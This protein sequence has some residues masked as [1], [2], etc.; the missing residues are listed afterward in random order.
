M[1]QRVAGFDLARALAV[2][3]M[4]IVNFKV[5][6]NADTGNP[7]LLG[8]AAL[9]EGRA[10]AL[11]VIL[12]GIGITLIT[13]KAKASQDDGLILQ[14]RFSLVKRG[15]LLVVIGL[16]FTPLWEAD[17]L[18][19]YGF[20]FLMAAALFRLNDKK[21]LFSALIVVLV[22][23][24]LMAFFD[25]ERNWIWA[26]L[27]YQDFWSVDGM[28]RHIVFN[29]FHP[30]FPWSA[31]LIFGMWLGRQD[32]ASKLVRNRLLIGSA[33]ML[34]AIECSFYVINLLLGDGKALDMTAEEVDFL[35]STSIIP[36]L[37]QYMI[38]AGSS[39]VI[40]IIGCLYLSERF[41][42]SR[43]LKWLHQTGKLALT[44]YI[45]HVVLGLGVLESMELLTNQTIDFSLVCS[46]LFCFLGAVFSVLWLRH[47][48]AGPYEWLF[49]KIAK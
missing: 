19:F 4:V 43:M 3:G 32:L 39:A 49:R 31:F 42:E 47:F 1:N 13:R 10:S 21:L 44:L 38:S 33:V 28:I 36:P 6:M 2:F 46:L 40:V 18:H 17:I 25:Y 30:I 22:F 11:F 35:F 23:P 15:L 48:N 16:I 7:F 14:S 41:A 20:Y 26:S 27:T 5:A 45:A 8:F 24:V 29:G 34:L 12:A 37:P 9:F